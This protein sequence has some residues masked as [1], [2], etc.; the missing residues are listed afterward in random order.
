MQRRFLGNT[1]IAVSEIAFGGVEIGLPYG[2]GVKWEED[3]LPEKD[4]VQLLLTAL[5]SGLN[6]F[7]TARLYGVSEN[8]MGRAF[9]GRRDEIVLCTKCRHF[10]DK[11][12][13]LPGDGELRKIIR[14]SLKESL[15][16]LQTDYID[17]YML[18]Q[19]D[20]EI[21]DRDVIAGEMEKLKAKGIVRSIGVSTYSADESKR[22]ITHGV[23]NVVQ[24]PFNLMDQRQQSLFGLAE[25]KGVGIVVRSVLLKGLLSNRGTG[26]HPMLAPVEK[27]IQQYQGL[28]NGNLT[29][30]PELAVKFA[31]S[32]PQVSSVLVGMDK[33][34][35]LKQSL[36]AA[37]GRYLSKDQLAH[38]QALSYP[39]PAFLNLPHWDKMGWLR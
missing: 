31:L 5:D 18:H 33:L 9:A 8:I 19:G 35:Y 29:S 4:A 17:L 3:M 1:G 14:Q 37:D 21:L 27:H 13:N 26:L 22:V 7:D 38:A 2:I 24:L 32:F 28:L 39:D 12:G 36:T 20:M 15:K 11:E 10:R 6:F 25:E 30:L 16:A 34:D 23:W